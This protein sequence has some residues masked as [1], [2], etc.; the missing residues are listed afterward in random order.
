MSSPGCGG[1]FP[2]SQVPGRQVIPYQ[3]SPGCPCGATGQG[4]LTGVLQVQDHPPDPCPTTAAPL[5]SV[6]ST[7]ALT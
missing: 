6:L 5:V 7:G 2:G 3:Q 4:L 1:H